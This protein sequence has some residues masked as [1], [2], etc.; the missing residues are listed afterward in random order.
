MLYLC[1]D[2]TLLLC[3]SGAARANKYIARATLSRRNKQ[4]M[5]LFVSMFA[6]DGIYYVMKVEERYGEV[7]V[8]RKLSLKKYISGQGLRNCAAKAMHNDHIQCTRALQYDVFSDYASLILD[9]RTRYIFQ[10]VKFL[11]AEAGLSLPVYGYSI[12]IST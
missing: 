1:N 9:T 10:H 7:N 6:F 8:E 2:V 3:Q 11:L 5:Y 12:L 4:Y